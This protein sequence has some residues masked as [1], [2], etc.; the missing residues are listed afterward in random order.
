MTTDL[1][2]SSSSKSCK[3]KSRSWVDNGGKGS[4]ADSGAVTGTSGGRALAKLVSVASSRAICVPVSRKSSQ[5]S[6]K[7][8]PVGMGDLTIGEGL[9]G[10]A[11]FDFDAGRLSNLNPGFT[12]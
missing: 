7:G 8:T 5:L 1:G 3:E 2:G 11:K 4:A 10:M 9:D 6:V 12:P